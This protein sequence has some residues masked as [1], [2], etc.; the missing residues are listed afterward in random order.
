M[1]L[2]GG[3]WLSETPTGPYTP[4]DIQ[5]PFLGEA[6]FFFFSPPGS[7]PPP[8]ARPRVDDLFNG[9]SPDDLGSILQDPVTENAIFPP[10]SSLL[11][12]PIEVKDPCSS[13]FYM[14]A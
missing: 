14:D 7:S 13:S 1:I 5:N 8:R 11:H 2:H 6:A 3:F 10:P 9:F 4:P 12:A